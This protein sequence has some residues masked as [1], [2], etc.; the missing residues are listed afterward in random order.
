MV[1]LNIPRGQWHT[2]R[3]MERGTVIIE[4]KDGGMWRWGRKTS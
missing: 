2:V 3:V 1:G 4:V